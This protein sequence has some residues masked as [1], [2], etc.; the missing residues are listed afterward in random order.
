MLIGEFDGRLTD[1]N[2]IAIPKKIRDELKDGLFLSNALHPCLYQ[3][4]SLCLLSSVIVAIIGCILT[5]IYPMDNIIGF[6]YF[7][8]SVFTPMIAIII[9]D[10][11]FLKKDS[12]DL[13]F[14]YLNIVSWIIGF[15]MYRY[16]MKIDII[17]GNS[18]PDIIFTIFVTLILNK[19]FVKSSKTISE[20]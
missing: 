15:I 7:I 1:K 10:Y 5:M 11:F 2:R 16:L 20:Y 8:S 9:V 6:L 13:N 3:L 12:S 14:N 19:I 18:I 4:N 17:L